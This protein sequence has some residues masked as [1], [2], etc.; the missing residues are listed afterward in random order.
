MIKLTRLNG[1]SFMVNAIF[2]EQI[3]SFPDTTI[4]LS[5]GKKL[6]VLDSEDDVMLRIV[7]F[8]KQVGIVRLV[9]DELEGK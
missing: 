4:T 7:E 5:N 1:Q 9:N 2:I 8:Y 6:V 3:Q